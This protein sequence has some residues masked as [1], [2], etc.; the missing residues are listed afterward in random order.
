ML[1]KL[2]WIKLLLP[3][4]VTDGLSQNPSCRKVADHLGVTRRI[5]AYHSSRSN[6][7]H[8]NMRLMTLLL[9]KIYPVIK[10]LSNHQ[11]NRTCNPRHHSLYRNHHRKHNPSNSC[12]PSR[13]SNR[14]RRPNKRPPK[15]RLK[16]R[17]IR[18]L[19]PQIP[20]VLD[21]A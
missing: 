14:S 17:T 13:N 7:L 19:H 21:G 4:L 18:L 20:K 1:P 8:H 3:P 6:H 2:Q 10:A 11:Y 5:N 12:L 9:S 15:S 16:R